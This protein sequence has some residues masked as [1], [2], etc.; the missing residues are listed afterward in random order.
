MRGV[1]WIV[2]PS[3]F[4]MTQAAI[5]L[6]SQ[7]NRAEATSSVIGT[8]AQARSEGHAPQRTH[9]AWKADGNQDSAHFG[10]SV[11]S[12][13]D[14]NGD[15]YDDVIV[16]A[17][18][19]D[20][21]QTDE[22]RAFVYHGSAA[23][24]SNTPDWTAESNQTSA[25]FGYSVASAGDVNGDGYDDVVVGAPYY[26]NGQTSEGRAFVY[27]G[28]PAGLSPTPD[29]IAES[30][31]DFAL[32]GVSVASAG[33]V[34]GDGYDDVIVG[35]YIYDNG[36]DD[37]GRAFAY[38]GSAGGLST[39]PDWTAESDQANAYFGTSVGSAG[40]VNGDGYDDVIVGAYSF[41]NGQT[42]EGRAF[43]YYGSAAGLNTTSNWTA[44][45]DQGS[46]SFGISVGSAG[47]VN[48]DGYADV[49]VGA[50]GYGNG[51]DY[52]GRAFVYDGSAAGLSTA[53]DWTAESNQAFAYFGFSVASAGD[54]NGDGYDDVIVGAFHYDNGQSDE[55]RAFYC[56]GSAAGP[57][58][59]P[60]GTAETNQYWA[61][62]SFSV[63]TAGDV[64]GDGYADVIVGAPDYDHG[65][66]DEGAAFVYRGRPG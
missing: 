17:Y 16:G 13:G 65:K 26:D 49:M 34:N 61:S 27:H 7:I 9:A 23:G 48:G 33:D 8:A 60:S 57:C 50:H 25:S 47:D 46:A 14:V 11:A 63:A 55:G 29:W 45:S 10:Y 32:F 3:V 18:L 1:R 41:E 39:T 31:Q 2:L 58:A 5:G 20:N 43:V 24:L 15:G 4:V 12:A 37:E 66:L 30:D 59:A 22:G 40:D 51:Q 38:Q 62:F 35:A 64:N 56:R 21:G 19:Y 54:A 36:Q 53:P 44:E 28:S 52:E 6:G 42:N